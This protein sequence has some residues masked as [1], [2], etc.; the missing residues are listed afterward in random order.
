MS[1]ISGHHRKRDDVHPLEGAFGSF[2]RVAV[3]AIAAYFA[4]DIRLFAV[5]E[6]GRIIH[7]FDPWFNFRA[8]QY[9]ADN[10]WKKF[11]TWFDYMSWYPLGRP[12]GTT[13]YPGMQV[14]AVSIYNTLKA[15]GSNY[16]MSLNDV[17]VFFPAWFGAVATMLVAF[18]T[19]ECSGSANSAVIAALVMSVVPAHTMRSVAGGYDNESLAV[20]AMCL[21]FF[22]WCR[23]LRNERSWWIGSLAGLAYVYM[24]AAWGGYTFV[25]NMVGLHAATL[26][27]LGQYSTSLHRAYSLFWIIGT[28]GAIQFPVVGLAPVKSLEQ[29]GPAFVFLG[30]QV[31]AFGE[32]LVKSRG[33]GGAEAWRIRVNVYAG[34]AV[35]ACVAIAALA[36]TGYFG[37]LSVRVKGLF[38]MHTRTGNPLVDSVA[39]HQPGTP[40]AYWRYLH[41]SYYVAPLGFVVSS[42]HYVKTRDASALFLPLYAVTA[43]YFANRMVRLII[44]LGPIASS[45]TGVGAGYLLDDL[46]DNARWA[47]RYLVVRDGAEGSD[48]SEDDSND[49]KA[50]ATNGKEKP[51]PF[52]PNLAKKAGKKAAKSKSGSQGSVADDFK[53]KMIEPLVKTYNSKNGRATRSLVCVVLLLW[54]CSHA[55]PFWD[56]SHMMARGMSQPSVMFKGTLQDGRTVMVKDYVEAYHWLRDNTPEDSRVM[57]WWDYGYQIAGMANRTSIADGNTWNHEHIANLARALTA[58]EEKAHRVIRHLADYVLVWAGGGADDLAKSP[59]LFRIGK[60]IGHDTGTV[61]MYEIQSKFGVDQ[62]GRPT[63]MMANSLLYKLVS[64]QGKVSEERFREVYTSKFRKVRIYEVVN[65]SQ[66]SRQW[67][68]DPENRMCDAPGSWYCPGQYPPALAK[69]TGI[70]KPAYRMPAF[71]KQQIEERARREAEKK[72]AA[73]QKAAEKKAA[74]E[75]RK[76]TDG[77]AAHEDL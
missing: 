36:P 52:S 24:V 46:I 44:F 47:Q 42:A 33:A 2:A 8:T 37:P 3:L 71:A 57:A 68:A 21:T 61:D 29:L 67:L 39:E 56:Y 51:A 5:R 19:A 74:E 76:A 72:E 75:L 62:Y 6:Y 7:E 23:S 66:K 38:K 26:V 45:L 50:A 4:Y 25:L 54:G 73:A 43:Y 65:V 17:C 9:L 55:R 64:F 30:M 58:P 16:A 22:V 14:T 60:S 53:A 32:R 49:A 34:A 18:L 15:L 1:P 41:Y 63:P 35:A 28:L 59:H 27:L 13:I 10:G 11:S 69:F 31:L 70:I 77:Q 20:T 40:D 12:V 48:D